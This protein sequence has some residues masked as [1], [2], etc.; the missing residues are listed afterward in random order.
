M[1]GGKMNA[2]GSGLIRFRKEDIA[3]ADDRTEY[4]LL[5]RIFWDQLKPFAYVQEALDKVWKCQEVEGFC[6]KGFVTMDILAPRLGR[7]K[8][9]MDGSREF[10]V[11]FQYEKV[12]A[13]CF[14]CGLIGHVLKR[15][16]NPH[17]PLD[18]EARKEWM[19]VEESGEE[20]DDIFLLKKSKKKNGRKRARQSFLKLSSKH[21]QQ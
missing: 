15:C 12:Q 18:L 10:W 5:V 13:I 11:Y 3:K 19:R 4:F 8:A 1:S 6:L 20:T 16:L 9:I 17:L 2:Y 21:H 7:E 14:K